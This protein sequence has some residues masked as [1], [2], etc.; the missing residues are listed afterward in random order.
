MSYRQNW[1]VS[2]ITN[3]IAHSFITTDLL[4]RALTKTR[5]ATMTKEVQTNTDRHTIRQWQQKSRTLL[6]LYL[7]RTN[8]DGIQC[9]GWHMS[10]YCCKYTLPQSRARIKL[11]TMSLHIVKN[12]D[13]FMTMSPLHQTNQI[14]VWSSSFL[15]FLHQTEVSRATSIAISHI[16]IDS[17][18]CHQLLPKGKMI[19]SLSTTWINHSS[20]RRK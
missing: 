3:N 15:I 5:T 1:D 11:T 20:P 8:N 18:A 9:K 16:Y 2:L 13:S 12:S 6:Q 14:T 17:Q 4:S 10:H 19:R 7:C